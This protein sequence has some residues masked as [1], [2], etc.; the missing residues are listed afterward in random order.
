MAGQAAGLNQKN[1]LAGELEPLAAANVAASNHVIHA[2]H[3]GTSF[4]KFRT[5]LFVPAGRN[6]RL[7]RA[8]YITHGISVLLAA[9]RAHQRNLFG[10]LFLVVIPFLIHLLAARKQL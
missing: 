10:F 1:T 4:C 9:V 3:V 2:D 6:L 8:H 7:F 5:V